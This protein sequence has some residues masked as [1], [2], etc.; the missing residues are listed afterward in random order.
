MSLE[1]EPSEITEI[2]VEETRGI[3]GSKYRRTLE[4][5]FESDLKSAKISCRAV[6]EAH[7]VAKQLRAYLFEEEAAEVRILSRG[8]TVYLLKV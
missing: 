6:A 4:K 3:R 8:R 1:L 5:F 7:L 2:E